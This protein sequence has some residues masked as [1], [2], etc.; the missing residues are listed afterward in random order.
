M[1]MSQQLI[2]NLHFSVRVRFSTNGL[3]VFLW[4]KFRLICLCFVEA[5]SNL[6]SKRKAKKVPRDYRGKNLRRCLVT[7]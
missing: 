4:A 1:G 2:C 3:I 5:S 6:S 7:G